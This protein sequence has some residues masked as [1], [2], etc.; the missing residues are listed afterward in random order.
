MNEVK[1]KLTHKKKRHKRSLRKAKKQEK[2][3]VVCYEP[4]LWVTLACKQPLCK[5]CRLKCME[6]KMPLCPYC[7][8]EKI[9][10]K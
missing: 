4:C 6:Y 7:K 5:L 1:S 8:S 10:I 3:C 9:V 2:N